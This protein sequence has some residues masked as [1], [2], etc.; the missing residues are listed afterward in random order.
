MK[1]FKEKEVKDLSIIQAGIGEVQNEWK[2]TAHVGKDDW[3]CWE[4]KVDFE[5]KIA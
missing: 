3:D 4:V 1:N 5:K 2:I